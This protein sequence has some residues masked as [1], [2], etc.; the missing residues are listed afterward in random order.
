MLLDR[1][2]LFVTV[3]RHHNLAKTARQM[4]VSASSVCQRL[5]SLE[6]DF[7]AKLY[8]KNKEGIELTG[9]GETFLTTANEVLNQLDNLRKTLNPDSE[10]AARSLTVGGTYGPSAKYLPSAI[11]AF[12]KAHPKI[13]LRFLTADIP[14]LD[15]LMRN[16]EVDIAIMQSPSKSTDFYMEP[17]AEDNLTFFV[18][19]MHPLAKKKNL[20]L[21]HL[22]EAPLIIREGKSATHQMLQQLKCR[23]I[24]VNVA[25]RCVSPDAVK[26]AV[27]GKMGVGILFYNVIADDIKR[28]DLK[29][30]KFS[31]LPVL[32]GKSYIVYSKSKSLSSTANEF[33][34]LLRSMKT[35]IKN[36]ANGSE[37]NEDPSTL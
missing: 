16:F 10:I 35:R 12:Q 21:E 34:T 31:G 8:K 32:T 17:F 24:G 29:S 18:H 33:L 13:K 28:K 3:A 15:R 14:H 1:F 22:A 7:G 4:H 6:N 11:A 25:L 20:D 9:A 27:R 23:G 36:P 19:P 2:E 5:K 30:L 26:A 37:T